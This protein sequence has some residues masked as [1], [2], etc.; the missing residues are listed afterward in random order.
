MTDTSELGGHHQD[1]RQFFYVIFQA[2]L[3]RRKFS[4]TSEKRFRTTS[5][6]F[7]TPPPIHHQWKDLFSQYTLLC[8]AEI[9]P[10]RKHTQKKQHHNPILIG[11]FSSL[12][13]DVSEAETGRP[14]RQWCCRLAS[15]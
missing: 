4:T 14:Q 2:L 15:G 10:T 3:T 13:Q 8:Q 5:T 11:C 7:S 6:L 1:E 9:N 12:F